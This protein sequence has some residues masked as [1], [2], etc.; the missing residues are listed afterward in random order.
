MSNTKSIEDSLTVD[1]IVEC[2]ESIRHKYVGDPYYEG[3][4]K[5]RQFL[6]PDDFSLE[7]YQIFSAVGYIRACAAIEGLPISEEHVKSALEKIFGERCDADYEE[8]TNAATKAYE[9]DIANMHF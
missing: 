5:K 8:Y 7:K 9:L 4:F 3:L 2:F 6:L 1:Q